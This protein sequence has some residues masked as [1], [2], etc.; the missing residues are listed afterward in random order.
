MVHGTQRRKIANLVADIPKDLVLRSVEDVV[1][2]D[3]E[4]D[5]AEAGTEVTAGPRHV[6]DDIRAELV[7]ELLQLLEERDLE[8]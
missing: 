8:Q 6:E 2:R 3:G 4:L 1:E 7:G 5:H